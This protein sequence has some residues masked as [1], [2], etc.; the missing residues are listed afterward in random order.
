MI[1]IIVTSNIL[2][3]ILS[4]FHFFGS[5]IIILSILSFWIYVKVS[6]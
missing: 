2:N 5:E 6:Y 1:S 4:I 3:Q